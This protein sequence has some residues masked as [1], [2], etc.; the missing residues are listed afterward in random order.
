[1]RHLVSI[2]DRKV[3]PQTQSDLCDRHKAHPAKALLHTALREY[4]GREH[5]SASY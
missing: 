2:I 5:F 1:M 4:A 3:S